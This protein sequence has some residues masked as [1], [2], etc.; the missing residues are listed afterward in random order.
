MRRRRDGRE[1]AALHGAREL[2]IVLGAWSMLFGLAA[3]QSLLLD[4]R[5]R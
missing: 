4:G 5:G 3:L 2:G 1:W